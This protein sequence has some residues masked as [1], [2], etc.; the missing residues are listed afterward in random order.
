MEQRD[1]PDMI[2]ALKGTIYFRDQTHAQVIVI[3]DRKYE[4]TWEF[5]GGRIREAFWNKRGC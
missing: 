2:L 3:P 1:K 5:S 4:L